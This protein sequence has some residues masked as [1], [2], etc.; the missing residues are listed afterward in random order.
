MIRLTSSSTRT[1]SHALRINILT[2]R[3]MCV[4]NTTH[5]RHLYKSTQHIIDILFHSLILFRWEM[6]L[7]LQVGRW[8]QS[9]DNS[10]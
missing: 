8:A 6:H 2:C 1:Q 10:T 9:K 5:Y 4:L 3:H 7:M